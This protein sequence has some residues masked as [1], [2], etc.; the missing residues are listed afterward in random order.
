MT[1]R[2]ALEFVVRVDKTFQELFGAGVIEVLP[3]ST[4][5]LQGRGD[6]RPRLCALFSARLEVFH[7][8]RQTFLYQGAAHTLI[9]Q[10]R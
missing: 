5:L 8:A 2:G 6:F 10:G 1:G 9:Y 3:L 4:V 7:A